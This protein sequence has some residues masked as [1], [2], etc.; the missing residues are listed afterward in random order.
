MDANEK[1]KILTEKICGNK[2]SKIIKEKKI[3]LSLSLR[4]KGKR[5]RRDKEIAAIGEHLHY[6]ASKKSNPCWRW[7]WSQRCSWR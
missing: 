3:S 6:F 4:A 5:R 7:L 2:A 1:F